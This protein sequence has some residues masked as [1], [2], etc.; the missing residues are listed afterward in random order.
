VDWSERR[1]HLAGALGAAVLRLAL[2]QKWLAQ[3]LDSR[4][5]RLTP[6]GRRQLASRMGVELHDERPAGSR[7]VH[8]KA[9]SMARPA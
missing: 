4:I 2:R 5:V 7:R 1:P 3:D 6:A 8:G 9:I